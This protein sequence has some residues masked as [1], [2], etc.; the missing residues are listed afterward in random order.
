MVY[1]TEHHPFITVYPD[2]KR[3]LYSIQLYQTQTEKKNEGRI[4]VSPVRNCR[5]HAATPPKMAEQN[6]KAYLI[7]YYLYSY[8]YTFLVSLFSMLVWFLLLFRLI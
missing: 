8:E 7:I 5:G 1:S 3:D 2:K 6:C 4:C